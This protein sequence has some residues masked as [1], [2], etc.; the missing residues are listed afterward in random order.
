MIPYGCQDISEEEVK[1]VVEVLNSDYLTQGSKPTLFAEAIARFNGIR[2]G[3]VFNSA[4][5][6][7]H[8]ACLAL[9]VN[10]QSHVWIT[11]N[12]F[13]ATANCA[14]YCGA[15][16]TFI[17]IDEETGLISVDSLN[18]K[19]ELA[20]KGKIPPPDVIIPIHYA[21]QL[22]AMPAINDIAK[23]LGA[24]I[25]EDASH[26]LGAEAPDEWPNDCRG[27]IH[28]FSFHPVKMITSGEGGAAITDDEVLAD[29]LRLY[30]N[31]GIVRDA[32]R[33][34]YDSDGPWYYEQQ[35]LGY[36]YR[37][38]D[39]Q[40]A[41]GLVQLKRL[42]DFLVKRRTIAE[43]YENDLSGVV[44]SVN[45][46]IN[47]ISSYH[48]YPVLAD[49]S[50]ADELF[51]YLREQGIATQKHYI[52]IPFQPYYQKKY[53]IDRSDFPAAERFYRRVIALPMFSRLTDDQQSYVVNCLKVF[54][55][56]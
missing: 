35:L 40:A 8:A 13:V 1:A 30:G 48:L 34:E 24:R 2:H 14:E 6:A 42:P 52:P 25:I 36:N 19:S 45:Q 54:H 4:T 39:I 55:D 26:A 37:M 41:L 44:Q 5:S 16:V 10:S 28:I 33:L 20:L 9:Q 32:E 29:K 11:A 53:N 23:R 18:E 17:D 49:E 47:G 46:K 22:A 3:V 50:R 27:D 31:H 12:S 43:R 7:L 15:T 51:K 21:G 56:G 38:T